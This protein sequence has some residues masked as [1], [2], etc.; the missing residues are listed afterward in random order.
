MHGFKVERKSKPHLVE[1]KSKP[2]PYRDA[3]NIKRQIHRNMEDWD[4]AQKGARDDRMPVTIK[5][6]GDENYC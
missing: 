6:K 2:H 1:K 4:N 3:P 5:P